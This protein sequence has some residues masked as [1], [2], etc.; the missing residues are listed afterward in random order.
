MEMGFL[1]KNTKAKHTSITT[2]IFKEV[3][4]VG[5]LAQW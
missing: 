2:Y 4:R 1:K 3:D 5:D